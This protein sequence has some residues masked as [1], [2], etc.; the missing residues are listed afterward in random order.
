MVCTQCGSENVILKKDYKSG[1]FYYKCNSCESTIGCWPG[2]K[3]PYGVFANKNMRQLRRDC[4]ALM[5]YFDDEKDRPRWK[6]S[7]HR[8]SLY[9]RL[10]NAMQM[11]EHDCHFAMMNEIQLEQAKMIMENWKV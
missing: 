4:H 5:D 8:R 3:K 10:A 6:T 7:R 11:D 1:K 9:R 2:T